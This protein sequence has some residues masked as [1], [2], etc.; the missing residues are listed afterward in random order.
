M[1]LRNTLAASLAAAFITVG[2]STPAHADK[3]YLSIG[4]PPPAVIVEPVPEPRTG[5]VWADGY[6]R[7]NGH[8]HVWV[9]GH[10]VKAKH[11]HRYVRDEWVEDHGRWVFHPGYWERER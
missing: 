1:T 2:A 6:W 5:Y 10:W 11:G 4:T 3:V 8:K 9:K 7:W